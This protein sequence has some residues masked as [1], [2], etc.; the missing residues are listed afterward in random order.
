[1]HS[2]T[3]TPLSSLDKIYVEAIRI[4]LSELEDIPYPDVFHLYRQCLNGYMQL[5]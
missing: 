4:R 2:E 3:S 1:M 5:T